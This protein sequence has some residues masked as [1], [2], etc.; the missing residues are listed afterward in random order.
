MRWQGRLVFTM[1]LFRLIAL[2]SMLATLS[3]GEPLRIA[4]F[5]ADVTP[6]IGSPLCCDGGVKPAREIVDPLSARGIILF[7][8]PKPVVMVAVD[9]TG[10]ASEG[11][12]EW[13]AELAKAAG[14]D[15]D[16]VT[17]N[18]LHQ[19]D[20]PEYDPAADRLLEGVGLGGTLYNRAFARTAL[21]RTAAAVR[22]AARNPVTVSHLGLGKAKVEKV[23]SSRRVLGEDGKV[24]YA[25][26]SSCR[27][28]EA[29]EAPEGVVDPYV[30]MVSFWQGTRPLAVI[31]YYA[32]HPQSYY[33]Q[34]GV[35]AD[36][37]GMA[38]GFRE[39]ALP[40][41]AH[42]H[43]NGAGGNVAA[44]KYNDGSREMRP[45]L[46]RRLADGMK[47]A[48]DSTVRT[49][50]QAGDAGWRVV[51]VLLPPTKSLEDQ[52]QLRRLMADEHQAQRLRLR[53]AHDLNWVRRYEAKHRIPL[54]LLTLGPAAVLYMPGE[55]FV[56]YQLAAQQM[57]PGR[58]VAM[59]AYGDYGPGYVGTR[60]SYTQGGYETGPVSRTDPGVEDV[61]MGG[62]RRLLEAGR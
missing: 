61:L 8:S 62:M 14:T 40:G 41:V 7:V 9:W 39:Q 46:A 56:E 47:A 30:R 16:H 42:I 1:P 5:R 44:G 26:M 27:I 13:R 6:P 29:R 23:A 45:V 21:E 24:K 22:A 43:F 59:A 28:P 4:T 33:G 18:T 58:F 36:F 19:H 12:D 20:A 10:I 32:T 60:I 57:R 25:R 38:R 50:I 31:T 11:W 34:G 17:V 51:P 48:F 15:A 35:S 53:T 2:L 37:V 54:F 3:A 52:Q 49:P 55:L